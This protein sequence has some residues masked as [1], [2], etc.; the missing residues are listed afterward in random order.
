MEIYD[1]IKDGGVFIC[2]NCGCLAND[3]ELIVRNNPEYIN[4]S[5]SEM[6]GTGVGSD[7]M[8]TMYPNLSYVK[9]VKHPS[10]VFMLCNECNAGVVTDKKFARKEEFEVASHSAYGYVTKYDQDSEV[11]EDD[12]NSRYGVSPVGFATYKGRVKTKAVAATSMLSAMLAT[13]PHL[14]ME[15]MLNKTYGSENKRNQTADEKSA[16]LLY[17]SLKRKYKVA[18]KSK[19]KELAN[20]IKSKMNLLKNMDMV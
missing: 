13:N 18:K 1:P 9:P 12:I 2:E 17:A 16:K 19:D 20:E 15:E 6:L 14:S 11:V 3:A 5:H 8:I 7:R 10:D 4:M